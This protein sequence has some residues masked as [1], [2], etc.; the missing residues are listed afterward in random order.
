M[1]VDI[2]K[3]SEIELMQLAWDGFNSIPFYRMIKAFIYHF[4]NDTALFL[5]D[6]IS[7]HKFFSGNKM[8]T[9]DGYFFNTQENIKEDTQI[10]FY[11]QNRIVDNLTEIGILKTERRGSPPRMYFK[12]NFKILAY[13][14]LNNTKENKKNKKTSYFSAYFSNYNYTDSLKTKNR[15]FENED[16]NKNKGNKN[17]SELLRNSFLGTS[18]PQLLRNSGLEVPSKDS[19]VLSKKNSTPLVLTNSEFLDNSKKAI[20]ARS[21]KNTIAQNGSSLAQKPKPKPKDIPL[22]KRIIPFIEKWQSLDL[23]Q[24]RGENTKVFK[25]SLNSLLELT[26][27]TA[28]DFIDQYAEYQDR[29]FNIEDW[30]KATDNFQRLLKDPTVWYGKNKEPL[31]KLSLSDFILNPKTS[32]SMFLYCLKTNLAGT[33]YKFPEPWEEDFPGLTD[34]FINLYKEET[35]N[36]VSP[37][38]RNYF[39]R[40]IA[41][42]FDQFEGK[43]TN[44]NF[45]MEKVN[46]YWSVIVNGFKDPSII[47]PRHLDTDVSFQRFKKSIAENG[48]VWENRAYN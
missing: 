22:P 16:D 43:R 25:D 1:K 31:K 44:L 46:Y 2:E 10:T 18:V 4:D 27:G 42:M 8:L 37:G 47:K 24:F 13:Y 28:F 36:F 21:K 48:V 41:F 35:G 15:F 38:D 26:N 20:L 19:L 45:P 12:L 3:M 5:A 6:L 14:A 33:R 29:K 34:L 23:R 9:K 11:T 40:A 32:K 30:S 7:K 39:V 17:K